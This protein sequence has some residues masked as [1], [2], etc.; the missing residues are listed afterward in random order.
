MK[1][2]L[3]MHTSETSHCAAVPV[4]EAI[5][6]YA[7][8]GY[9]GVV[10][11]D[12]FNDYTLAQWS[13]SPREQAECWLRS[14][15]SAQETAKRWGIRV[16]FGLEARS[17]ENLND[18]L[19]YGAEPEFVLENPELYRLLPE[20]LYGLCRKY[21]VL[22]VQAHPFRGMCQLFD[23]NY[24]DGVEAYNGNPFHD[25]HNDRAL[26]VAEANPRLI[27]TSGSDFH[28]VPDFARGGIET[29]RELHTS[30]DLKK[31]L[32]DRAFKR[33]ETN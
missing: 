10:L 1:W 11:T 20:E 27:A 25:S 21:D 12:H 6:A 15:R 24:L 28:E 32:I 29:D 19:I 22:M 26:A 14:F 30:A 2:E 17:T 33:I 23:V 8:R 13:G 3:H 5:A 16:L 31:C 18:F 7:A 9:D 4:M